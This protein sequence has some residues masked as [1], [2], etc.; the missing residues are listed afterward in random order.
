MAEDFL[1]NPLHVLYL[2]PLDNPNNVL[3]SYSL[4]DRNCGRWKRAM[5]VALIGNNKLK[6]VLGEYPRPGPDAPVLQA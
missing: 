3:V 1:T 5:E 6:F 2:H 4:D